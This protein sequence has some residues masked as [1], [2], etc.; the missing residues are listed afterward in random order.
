M[1]DITIPMNLVALYDMSE[2]LLKLFNFADNSYVFGSIRVS[3]T[4]NRTR[5]FQL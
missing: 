1:N 5:N 4:D 2:I 3:Q